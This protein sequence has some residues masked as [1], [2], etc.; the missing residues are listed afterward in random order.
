MIIR[1]ANVEPPGSLFC[2]FQ[3]FKDEALERYH[4]AMQVEPAELWLVGGEYWYAVPY[5][6]SGGLLRNIIN[7]L[8]QREVFIDIE[9]TTHGRDELCRILREHGEH[10]L[11]DELYV[12]WEA[13]S[14]TSETDSSD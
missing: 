2:G 11:A 14:G 5:T 9:V 3:I 4:R 12:N 10:D 1:Y 8:E 7:R 6:V 13:A